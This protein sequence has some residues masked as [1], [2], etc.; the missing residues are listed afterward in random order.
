[1]QR[2]RFVGL[3]AG[4]GLD[5]LGRTHRLHVSRRGLAFLLKGGKAFLDGRWSVTDIG[6]DQDGK[7]RFGNGLEAAEVLDVSG[8]II[9]PGFIDV[10]ADNGLSIPATVPIFEKYKVADGVTTALQMHGGTADCDDFYR[11]LG[12]IG[13]VV[14]YGA[15]TFV[16]VIR[17]RVAAFEERR[18]LITRCLHEGALGVSHSLEYQP[19]PFEELVEY[20]KL[21][22]AY[23]RPFFLHLRYSS[24]ERELDGVDEA[25]RL[26]RASGAR[27]HL[28]HLHS[29]GG[30]FRMEEALSRIQAGIAEGLELTCCVYPYSYWATY[31]ASLRF[32]AGWQQR[33]GLTYSDLRLVGSN[34]RLSAESFARYRKTRVLV[35]V[36]EGTMPLSKTFDLAIEQPFCMIASDGGIQREPRSNSH[37]RGAACFATALRYALDRG[38]P[39]ERMLEKMT[40]LPARVMRHALGDRGY[41]K[42]GAVAD[43]TVF[44][45]AQVRGNATVEN[46]N[47]T[48]SGIDLVLVQGSKACLKRGVPIRS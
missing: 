33:Y 40:A 15:S 44:D 37:P 7:L 12:R 46:P 2:R 10:L 26:A 35:A 20:A 22:R 23:D 5:R 28:A 19:A 29:T 48:S 17:N 47:Q 32:A 14:N 11:R 16:M 36:P 1:M 4:A 42:E 3:L 30:T 34:E 25:I 8:K 38:M 43:L 21:A 27:V 6:V 24:A 9:S 18:R 45:P 39:L 31:L 41:L 13:H